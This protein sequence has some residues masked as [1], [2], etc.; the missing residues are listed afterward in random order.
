MATKHTYYRCEASY[1][2]H[3]VIK[4]HIRQK[5]K[6]LKHH[7]WHI[8]LQLYSK[9][10][11]HLYHAIYVTSEGDWRSYHKCLHMM[12]FSV[13]SCW[14]PAANNIL[15]IIC[16]VNFFRPYLDSEGPWP[17][18]I[19]LT[20]DPKLSLATGIIESRSNIACLSRETALPIDLTV[21]GPP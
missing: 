16:V 15:G 13:I 21:T 20:F 2:C 5:E 6:Q 12:I 11:C 9:L 8:H 10:S 7:Q 17:L 19:A 14:F 4:N 1:H 18:I 3:S